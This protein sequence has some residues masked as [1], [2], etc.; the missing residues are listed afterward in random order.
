VSKHFFVRRRT[1]EGVAQRS[2]AHPMV[3][4]ATALGVTATALP[5]LSGASLSAFVGLASLPVVLTLAGWLR[6][7]A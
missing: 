7:S 2:I 3:A 4:C 6:I 5:F 1:R